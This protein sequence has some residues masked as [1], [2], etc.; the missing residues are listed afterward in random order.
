MIHRSLLITALAL[1]ASQTR[2][3]DAGVEFFESKVRPLL[4]KRCY[5]CHS[6]EKKQKG[7]LSLDQR[8]GW[9]TGGDSG[10]ALVPGNP[11]K[12]LLIE[13]VRHKDKDLA[14]PPKEKLPDGE[15][16][17]LEQWVKMGAPDPR[18]GKV[19][20]ASKKIDLDEG[21][22]FWAFQPVAKPPVPAVQDAKWPAS[23]I[24]RFV[25]ARLEKEKL[26]PL[27][28]ADAR[29][30]IR[31]ASLDLIGLSPSPEEVEAFVADSIRDPQSA[32]RNLVDRLLKS[33]HFGERW[34]RHWLDIAR[35]AES[36]GSNWNLPYPVA[37]RH[38]DYVIAAFNADKPYDRFLQEQLAGDLLPASND[39]QRNEQLIATG[40]LAIGQKDLQSLKPQIY[41]MDIVDEQIDCTSR[42]VLGLSIACARCHDH[43]FDPIRTEDYYALAGIFTSTEPMAG[44]KRLRKRDLP[45]T[46]LQALAGMP[47]TMTEA[48]RDAFVL[49]E[50]QA[51][52]FSLD[53]RDAEMLLGKAETE[54]ATAP[55]NTKAADEVAKL[56]TDVATANTKQ[57]EALA[58]FESLNKQDH[59]SLAGKAMAVRDERK[60]A[61]TAVLIRGEVDRPGA[62]VPRGVPAVLTK[63][64]GTLNITRGQSGRL[65]LARW[66]TSPEHPLTARVMVNRVWLH[67]IGAGIVESV[68]D[69]GKTG[70][71]PSHPELLDF[72][73]Q[74]FMQ[75]GWSV[76]Q[77]I[78]EIMLSR[79]YRLSSSHDASAYEID[80]ANRLL[81]RANRVRLDSEALRDAMLHVGGGLDLA[82]P[83]GSPVLQTA[84]EIEFYKQK[85]LFNPIVLTKTHLL[86][87]DKI[88]PDA[89]CMSDNC[90]HVHARGLL[91]R[92]YRFRSVYLPS[93]RGGNTEI[94]ATFDGAA[95]EE[96][97]GKRAVTTVPTQ[98]LFLMNS[99]FAIECA[100]LL[101]RRIKAASSDTDRIRL[102]FEY[103]LA[104]PP[105]TDELTKTTAFLAD[106]PKLPIKEGAEHDS[107]LAWTVFC[108]ILLGSAEFRYRY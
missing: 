14:M 54:L 77:L 47:D 36:T 22:K 20:S 7:G 105:T 73:A 48:Q 13:A 80:P 66:L 92:D 27:N 61:D 10:P 17:T 58:R 1:T 86:E 29:T 15:I 51:T 103:T 89:K 78:R 3:A 93:I 2:A 26:H 76:K 82:P 108:Q 25:L 50:Y 57:E 95:P 16:A 56:K 43:K 71:P 69:F 87:A 37:W 83:A 85:G 44:V 104:R 84:N 88:T 18:D 52:Q 28:D 91:T 46:R 97:V 81:W 38:R 55:G 107:D 21:R 8:V 94:R 30:L 102:A 98:S 79:M 72:L 49:A 24:D 62:I 34:G 42:A 68:D 101:A 100:K 63:D 6:A 5:E 67:L 99:P 19:A 35:F 31:R 70:Q 41:K 64:E 75:N 53:L 59:A 90:G 106:Y 11:D 60:P 45:V 12:S 9:Q 65:E 39:A 74:R 33:A 4:I 40:F 23:D 96:V 32:F